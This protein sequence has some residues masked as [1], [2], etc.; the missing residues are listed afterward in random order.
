MDAGRLAMRLGANRAGPYRLSLSLSR[1]V[2]RRTDYSRN[3][4]FPGKGARQ[5]GYYHRRKI[6]VLSRRGRAYRR[7]L[8]H[9][10]S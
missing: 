2:A 5:T 7:A 3:R 6:R 8:V 9:D 10:L 4:K 1:A